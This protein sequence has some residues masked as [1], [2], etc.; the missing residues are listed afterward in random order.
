M[1]FLPML[2]CG[3][4]AILFKIFYDQELVIKNGMLLKFMINK[5][6]G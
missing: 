5:I 3:L 1:K 2:H 6:D 4:E